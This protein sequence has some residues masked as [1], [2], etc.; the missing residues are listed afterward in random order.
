MSSIKLAFKNM[1]VVKNSIKVLLSVKLAVDKMSSVFMAV[2][3]LFDV[4]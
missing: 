1:F 3:N 4:K 2:K